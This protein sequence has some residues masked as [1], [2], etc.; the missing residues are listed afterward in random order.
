MIVCLLDFL[1]ELWRWLPSDMTCLLSFSIKLMVT[2]YHIYKD[3]WCPH[4]DEKLICHAAGATQV[5]TILLPLSCSVIVGHV[6]QEICHFLGNR[7]PIIGNHKICEHNPQYNIFVN[8]LA[9][10]KVA[11]IYISQQ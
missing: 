7:M 6:P 1:L 4:I 2:G 10:A 5:I 8:K 11:Y 3:R 9:I